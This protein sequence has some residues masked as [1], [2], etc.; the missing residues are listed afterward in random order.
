MVRLPI[1]KT[2]ST[3]MAITTG[4]MPY[5]RPVIAGTS[6]WATARYESSH[7]TKMEGITKNEPA[8]IPP[9]VPCSLHPM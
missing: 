4:C 5:R 6:E 8:T 7:K 3:T 2:A 1:L 9:T